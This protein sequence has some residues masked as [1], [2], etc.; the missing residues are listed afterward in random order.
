[1]KKK[2]SLLAVMALSVL[3]YGCGKTNENIDIMDISGDTKD[4]IVTEISEVSAD[5]T[6]TDVTSAQAETNAAESTAESTSVSESVS[7]PAETTAAPEKTAVPETAAPEDKTVNM[8]TLKETYK[9]IIT[10]LSLTDP[11]STVDYTLYD[12]NGDSIPE[13][14]VKTGTCEAD[15]KITFYTYREGTGLVCVGDGFSGF[16]SVYC[17]DKSSNSFCTEMGQMGVGAITWFAF[18]GENVTET[19]SQNDI[20]YLGLDNPDDAYAPYG[21]FENL[22]SANCYNSLA[23]GW[24]TYI[25]GEEKSGIDFSLIDNY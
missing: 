14:I 25:G 18:D 6:E 11:I 23:G 20:N 22:K 17:V 10:S 2:I 1:M 12:M 9:S 8:E 13:L 15:Y 19:K 3:L 24:I 4:E 7:E 21:D 5:V 16:H